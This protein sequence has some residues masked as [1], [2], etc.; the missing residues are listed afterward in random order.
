MSATPTPLA[1]ENASSSSQNTSIE[2]DEELRRKVQWRAVCTLRACACS[3][4]L[5]TPLLS[6]APFLSKTAQS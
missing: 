4:W 6:L 2:T 3:P 1:A 5:A